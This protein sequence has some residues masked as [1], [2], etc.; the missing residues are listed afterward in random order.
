MCTK[1]SVPA[2]SLTA[3]F[4]ANDQMAV[5]AIRALHD[6]DVAIPESVK[7]V[8]YDNTFIASIVQPALTT[9][10]VPGYK[11][12]VTAA[13]QLLDRIENKNHETRQHPNGL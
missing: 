1:Q 8:G 11:M 7:V 13:K 4:A 2:F 9:I 3:I 12:G 10:S 6:A 5:G